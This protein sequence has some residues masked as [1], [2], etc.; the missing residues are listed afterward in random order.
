MY[1]H[2]NVPDSAR[3]PA[4]LLLFRHFCQ[5]LAKFAYLL[6]MPGYRVYM[7][8]EARQV[9]RKHF[10]Q[11]CQKKCNF[12]GLFIA[13]RNCVAVPIYRLLTAASHRSITAF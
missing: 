1:W 6:P 5:F 4:N 7:I 13:H 2:K 8:Y 3:I 10:H 11:I 9:T 12:K